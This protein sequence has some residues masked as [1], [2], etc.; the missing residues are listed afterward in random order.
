[1]LTQ[2]RKL[3]IY[4]NLFNRFL[5]KKEGWIRILVN[6]RNMNVNECVIPYIEIL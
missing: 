3:F 6:K 1:M 5:S 4:I 2:K